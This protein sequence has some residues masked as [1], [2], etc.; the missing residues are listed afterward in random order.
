MQISYD[1]DT[2]RVIES[3]CVGKKGEKLTVQDLYPLP[4]LNLQE[5]N[6]NHC[7]EQQWIPPDLAIADLNA[8]LKQ[9]S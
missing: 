3:T 7:E 9:M 4:E 2:G 6:Y 5:I 1:M 8:L